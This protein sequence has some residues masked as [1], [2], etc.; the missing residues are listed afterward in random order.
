MEAN[1]PT[2]ENAMPTTITVAI[3]SRNFEV[4]L[5]SGVMHYKSLIVSPFHH[6]RLWQKIRRLANIAV[7]GN[8]R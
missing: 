8:R 7:C 5:F 6:Y 3:R 4:D 2:G 1:P